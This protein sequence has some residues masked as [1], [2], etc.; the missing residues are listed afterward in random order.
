MIILDWIQR[1]RVRIIDGDMAVGGLAFAVVLIAVVI[2]I[3]VL[4][5]SHQHKY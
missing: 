4:T 3:K 5:K 2:V 1:H